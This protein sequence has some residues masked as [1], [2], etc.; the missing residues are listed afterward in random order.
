MESNNY[1]NWVIGTVNCTVGHVPY[2]FNAYCVNKLL[3]QIHVQNT[4]R[5]TVFV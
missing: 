4:D 3:L 2:A 1:S 5:R